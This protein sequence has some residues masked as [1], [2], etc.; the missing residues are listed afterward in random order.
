MSKLNK[1]NSMFIRGDT[2]QPLKIRCLTGNL[3]LTNSTKKLLIPWL[4]KSIL[5]VEITKEC[6][7]A[8][9]SC[10]R[11]VGSWVIKIITNLE[12]MKK[13]LKKGKRF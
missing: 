13:K 4:F 11:I 10:V 5:G 8:N 1:I 6:Q 7:N 3:S 9:S 12:N 2:I